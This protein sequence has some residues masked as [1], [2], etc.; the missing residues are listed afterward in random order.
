MAVHDGFYRGVL[1]A[2]AHIHQAGEDTLHREIVQAVGERELV[3]VAR[4]ENDMDFSGMT[5]Y[6]KAKRQRAWWRSRSTP[7]TQE[8]GER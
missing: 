5:A 2:L 4:A 1:A 6:L 8:T 3:R 7:T